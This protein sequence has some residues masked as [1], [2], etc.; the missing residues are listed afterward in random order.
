MYGDSFFYCKNLNICHMVAAV[1]CS[2]SVRTP[3]SVGFYR[4]GRVASMEEAVRAVSCCV[5][6]MQRRRKSTGQY[7]TVLLGGRSGGGVAGNSYLS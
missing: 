5:G 6:T 3:S 7:I 4:G 2:N 1:H